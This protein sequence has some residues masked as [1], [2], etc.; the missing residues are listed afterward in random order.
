[1]YI[2][3]T[4]RYSIISI[5]S[6]FSL[7]FSHQ[8]THG[9][10]GGWQGGHA[11]FYGGGDASGTMG[12]YDQEIKYKLI[13]LPNL[14]IHILLLANTLPNLTIQVELV[15]METCIAKVTGRTQRL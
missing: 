11:T 6:I 7:L 5:L 4:S 2:A 8:G 1:M 13:S 9:D 3:S 14:F 12:T 10:D 15:A